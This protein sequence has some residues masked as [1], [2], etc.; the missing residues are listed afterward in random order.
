MKAAHFGTFD[1]NNYG[2]LLFPYILEYRLPHINFTHVSPTNKKTLFKDSKPVISTKQANKQTFDAVIIGGGNIIHT[3]PTILETYKNK[4]I[5]IFA[6]PSL[7]IGAA[8]LAG[9]LKVPLVFNSPSISKEYQSPIDKTFFKSV[10]ARSEYIS[11]REKYSSNCAKQFTKKEVKTVP[12]TAF[13]I[14]RMWPITNQEQNKE[15]YI[16]LNLN[17]RYHSPAEET[18][19]EIDKLSFEQNKKIKFIIIGACHNDT[20]FTK[21]V[22][23]FL[24]CPFEIIPITTIKEMAY[25]IAHAS[26]FI[27]S[28]MHGFITSLSYK[29]PAL[30]LLKKR[31]MKKFIGLLK[32]TEL[33]EN[34]ICSNWQEVHKQIEK[35][36]LLEKSVHEKITTELNQHWE[37][38]NAT[39]NGNGKTNSKFSFIINNYIQIIIAYRLYINLKQGLTQKTNKFKQQLA[40]YLNRK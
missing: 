24:K 32:I 39:I 34:V 28:S 8:K 35:P 22:T 2:D 19:R 3:D 14:A 37:N 6:Y 7:W 12:D 23:Q 5:G 40:N 10:F 9:K 27:G 16:L 31:P 30:L 18:A 11:F 15:N 26:L 25:S 20:E 21:N 1:V 17:Q 36:A 29:V 38:I 4:G 33:N 13:D